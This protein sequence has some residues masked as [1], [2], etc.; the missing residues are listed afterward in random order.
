[1]EDV[2]TYVLFTCTILSLEGR[3]CLLQVYMVNHGYAHEAFCIRS[4]VPQ[5]YPTCLLGSVIPSIVIRNIQ[6]GIVYFKE[7]N[8]FISLLVLD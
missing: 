2:N 4:F 3:S 5:D 1:M 8:D 6:F 7:P